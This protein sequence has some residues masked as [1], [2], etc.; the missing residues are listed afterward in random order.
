MAHVEAS[1]EIHSSR[2]LLESVDERKRRLILSLAFGAASSIVVSIAVSQILLGIGLLSL[3]VFRMPLRFPPIK[4][5]LFLFFAATVAA[6]L[7][8]GDPWKGVPQI[9]KFFV[10]GIVLLVAS[11]F[12]GVS[13]IRYLTL[14]WAA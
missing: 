6:D 3:L 5:P 8:S 13:Q 7:L 2:P 1:L 11:A 14:A 9:R 12:R 10:F 4:L